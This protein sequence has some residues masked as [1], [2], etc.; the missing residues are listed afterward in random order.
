MKDFVLDKKMLTASGTFYPKG[1]A[2]ILFPD[3][4]A[5]QRVADALGDQYGEVTLL[6]P[7]T[8]QSE[9]NPHEDKESTLPLPSVG[10]EGQTAIKFVELAREGHHALMVKMPDDTVR[11]AVMDLVRREKFSYG[12]RYHSLAIEDLE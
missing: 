11:D 8:I 7:E 10:T 2:V 4:D 6:D 3:G 9:L 5:A 12:Q 1:Y